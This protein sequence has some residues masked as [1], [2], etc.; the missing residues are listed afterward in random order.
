MYIRSDSACL[1]GLYLGKALGIQVVSWAMTILYIPN[2]TGGPSCCFSDSELQKAQGMLWDVLVA[3]QEALRPGF[4]SMVFRS[5]QPL[6]WPL[7]RAPAKQPGWIQSAALVHTD[8]AVRENNWRI[9]GQWW[10]E[11]PS[12][13]GIWLDTI[14]VGHSLLC[15]HPE[16]RNWL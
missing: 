11:W 10:D 7:E 2:A 4:G 6:V 13:Q 3:L 14:P 9:H 5:W 15:F 12:R 1:S 16:Q 8:I